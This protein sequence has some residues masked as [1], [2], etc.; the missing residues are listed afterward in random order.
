MVVTREH[1][2]S[3]RQV[4]SNVRASEASAVLSVKAAE[5]PSLLESFESGGIVDDFIMPDAR[6]EA[7]GEIVDAD[8]IHSNAA[9]LLSVNVLTTMAMLGAIWGN[10]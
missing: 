1:R 5:N 7:A 6:L 10:L 9:A 8:S 4:M 3:P 2:L